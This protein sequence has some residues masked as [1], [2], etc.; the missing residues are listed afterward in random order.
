MIY[1][2]PVCRLLGGA[3]PA[4]R[5]ERLPEC[6]GKSCRIFLQWIAVLLI[7]SSHAIALMSTNIPGTGIAI[8]FLLANRL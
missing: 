4:Q 2:L 8:Y 5:G 7:D 1:R 3:T 6:H